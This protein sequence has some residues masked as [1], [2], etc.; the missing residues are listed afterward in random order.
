MSDDLGFVHRFVPGESWRTLLLLHGTGGNENDL[1][2][3]GRA[4]DPEAALLSPRGKVLENGM[5]RF[6]RRLAMGVFDEEDLKARTFELAEFVDKAVEHYDLDKERVVAVGYSNGANIAASLL[7]LKPDVLAGAALLHAMP[8]FEPEEL[9]DLSDKP[10]L[11]TA[12]RHD[13]M[14]PGDRAEVLADLY[15]KAGADATL[16]WM[17]GG[18]ELTSAELSTAARWL[19]QLPEA[20]GS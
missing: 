20:A 17:P 9:P 2:P 15:R 14:V 6:F 8:P 18:H 12:G 3:L 5:P 7:L 4:L 13:P 1:L 19:S 10:I 16:Q 11:L